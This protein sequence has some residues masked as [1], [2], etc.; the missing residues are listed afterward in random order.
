MELIERGKEKSRVYIAVLTLAVMGF[1]LVFSTWQAVRRQ[2]D[3]GMQHLELSS[4]AVLQAVESSLRRRAGM[5]M[6][7]AGIREFFQDLED[8]GDIL[9]VGILDEDGARIISEGDMAQPAFTLPPEGLEALKN[10]ERWQGESRYGNKPVYVALRPINPHPPMRRHP[11]RLRRDPPAFPPGPPRFLMVGMDMDKHFAVYRGFYRTALFQVAYILGAAV[12]LWVLAARFISRRELAGKAAYLERFQ[13]RLIDSL[14]DAL[15]ITDA[16]TGAILAANPAARAVFSQYDPLLGKT[17]EKIGLPGVAAIALDTATTWV[18]TALGGMHLE[19]RALPFQGE[20]NEPAFMLIARNRTDIRTL[21]KNLAD[22]EKLAAVGSL[23]AG[24]AH[25]IRNPLA[26]LRG[27]AQYFAKKLAGKEPEEEYAN[28]MVREADRLNRVITDLLYLSRPRHLAAEAVNMR[29]MY[30]EI[31]S[32]LRFE[33][34]D[35][36]LTVSARFEA[37]EVDADPDALKQVLLNLFLNAIEAMRDIPGTV[38]VSSR[39]GTHSGQR[40]VWVGIADTGPGMPE[41]VRSRAFEPFHTTKRTGTG[42]GLALVHAIMRA[43]DG[44][45][46]ITSPAGEDPVRPGCAVDLF[47]PA[48]KEQA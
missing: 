2:R 13:A 28:T 37:P 30:E 10:K 26:A 24:V 5:D 47:F 18:Q 34:R 3:A 8:N 31:I 25:E 35:C 39:A 1:A 43:H 4:L 42:L 20:E 12:F 6:F 36:N 23:A 32:L 48:R 21:E 16:A 17:L 29:S 11:G 9:F 7:A 14:P 15:L 41:E 33:L 45:V 44:D 19:M 40:G 46:V 22:A 38:T 27:F